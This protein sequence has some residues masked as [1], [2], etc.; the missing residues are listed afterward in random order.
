MLRSIF[1][2]SSN[3]A[4]L[5]SCRASSKYPSRLMFHKNID[6]NNL[7][8]ATLITV[9]LF[10]S[11]GVSGDIFVYIPRFGEGGVGARGGGG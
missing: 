6:F 8:I 9:I 2:L 11:K 3:C 10:M 7:I 4:D 1:Q 5:E